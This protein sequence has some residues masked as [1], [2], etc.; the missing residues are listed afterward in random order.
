M[1]VC[2]ECGCRRLCN[3]AGKTHEI[4]GLVEADPHGLVVGK[5]VVT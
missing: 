4:P 5:V 3:F 1:A 2:G